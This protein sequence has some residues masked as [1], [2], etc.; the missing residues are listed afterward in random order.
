[1]TVKKPANPVGLNES[2]RRILN[3]ILLAAVLSNL[4]AFPVFSAD[5]PAAKV[6][7]IVAPNG[8]HPAI[9][10]YVEFKKTN[11]HTELVSLESV[12][13]QTKGTDD[14][15]KLK[16]FLYEAWREKHLGYVLLVGDVDVMPV[17]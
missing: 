9:K 6:F 15:E 2:G 17:R 10:D 1:M 5:K 7:F 8:F 12:L 13:K 4:F 11:I 3:K 14:P 16:R